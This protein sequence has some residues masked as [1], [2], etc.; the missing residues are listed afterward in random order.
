[1]EFRTKLWRSVPFPL[2]LLRTT[3]SAAK[4]GGREEKSGVTGGEE[5]MERLGNK[6]RKKRDQI[7]RGSAC[8]YRKKRRGKVSFLL[9]QICFVCVAAKQYTVI[10]TALIAACI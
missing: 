6:N 7:K 9:L 10:G 5:R 1:M 8:Y 4:E 3:E 2:S